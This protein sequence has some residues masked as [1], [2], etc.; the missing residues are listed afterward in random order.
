MRMTEGANSSSRIDLRRADW[1]FLLPAPAD[2]SYQHLVLLGGPTGLVERLRGAGIARRVSNELPA[3]DPVDVVAILHG[4]ATPGTVRQAIDAL[5][6]DGSLYCEI[7]RR[8]ANSLMMTPGRMRRLLQAHSLSLT[9]LYWPVPGFTG[10]KRYVPLDLAGPL[11]WYFT[12]LYVDGAPLQ[13]L[14]ERVV[15]TSTNYRAARFSRLVPWYALTASAGTITPASVLGYPNCRYKLRCSEARPFL[16]TMGIDEGSRV[17]IL[18]FTGGAQPDIVFKVARLP[19]VNAYVESEQDRL[20]ELRGRLDGE[21]RCGVPVPLGR[22]SYGDLAVGIES[23]APGGSL[24]VSSGRW[25]VGYTEKVHD[26]R[27]ATEWLAAFHRQVQLGPPERGTADFSARIEHVLACYADAFGIEPS[28]ERLFA[29]VRAHVRSLQDVPLPVVWQHGDFGPWNVYRRGNDVTVIDWEVRQGP[30]LDPEGPPLCDL[31]YFVTYW[32]FAA[33]RLYG[34]TAEERGLRELFL[35]PDR[36]DAIISAIWDAIEAYLARL[37]VDRRFVSPL[38]V[39]T[40]VKRALEELGRHRILDQFSAAPRTGNQFV[41]WIGMLA[42][43]SDQLF[44]A[45][46]ANDAAAVER[47]TGFRRG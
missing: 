36:K 1:R 22:F 28:E 27:L 2:G 42:A 21:I 16:V 31:L 41:D 37:A 26:L 15:R 12:T 46:H 10:G 17:A 23:C 43:R 44:P 9:G 18:P 20:A 35:E 45:E 6:P 5:T 13:R 25:R 19:E 33:R 24:L 29:M 34:E 8:S 39:Y 38:L 47:H 32:S 14:F 40:W 30:I 3:G 4:A 7:D 11:H